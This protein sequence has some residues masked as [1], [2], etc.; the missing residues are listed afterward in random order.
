MPGTT[1]DFTP[2]AATYARARPRYPAELYDWLASLV[3][4]RDLAWDAATG[5]PAP[6]VLHRLDLD[7]WLD[8]LWPPS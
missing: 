7:A 1:P 2:F 8:E 5:K 4:R 6:D 3:E